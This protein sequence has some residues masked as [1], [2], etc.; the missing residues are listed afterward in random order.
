MSFMDLTNENNTFKTPY[1]ITNVHIQQ[2]L[3]VKLK[4]SVF[5]AV[6]GLHIVHLIYRNTLVTLYTPVRFACRDN[7]NLR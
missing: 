6:S 7:C 5:K 2:V 4:L 3:V 1:K